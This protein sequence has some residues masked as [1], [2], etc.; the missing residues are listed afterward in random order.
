MR[1]CQ[2]SAAVISDLGLSVLPDPFP[3]PPVG[4]AAPW[5]AQLSPGWGCRRPV[6]GSFRLS[7]Q[8]FSLP[9]RV[10]GGCPV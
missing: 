5:Q 8:I 3:S 2:V 4:N 10:L 1:S 9:S 6:L 7:L